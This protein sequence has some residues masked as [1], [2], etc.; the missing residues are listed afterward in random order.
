[1]LNIFYNRDAEIKMLVEMAAE[2]EQLIEQKDRKK[3]EAWLK[4]KIASFRIFLQ[5]NKDEYP[6]LSCSDIQTLLKHFLP[7][8]DVTAPEVLRQMEVRHRKRQSSIDSARKNQKKKRNGHED[9]RS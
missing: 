3:Y 5:S 2:E 4:E 7:R 1:M 9:L 6:L 8:R